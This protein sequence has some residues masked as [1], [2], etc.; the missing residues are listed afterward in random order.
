MEMN[1]EKMFMIMLIAGL[2]TTMNTWVAKWSDIRIL[3]MNDMYMILLMASLMIFLTILSDDK[4]HFNKNL[5]IFFGILVILIFW[6]IRKQIFVTDSQY[7]KGMI[8]HH[9]MAI[10][11]SEKIRERTQNPQIKKL[12]DQIIKSQTEEIKQMN[13]MLR[14]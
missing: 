7:L 13:D 1:H 2:F 8:P 11:M 9:S 12:A 4:K 10:L 5:L 14:N 3:H 6:L